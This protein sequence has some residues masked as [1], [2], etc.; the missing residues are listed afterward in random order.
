[1]KTRTA[2]SAVA[3]FCDAE[4]RIS[5]PGLTSSRSQTEIAAHISTSLKALLASQGEY[6]GQSG[7]VAHAK[8]LQK[9]LCLRILSL[10]ELLD[11]S[12]AHDVTRKHPVVHRVPPS[13]TG[14]FYSARKCDP[15]GSMRSG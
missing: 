12:I 4:L 8:D 11:L 7:D 15:G 2:R 3:G 5:V 14:T 6:V 10:A 9:C 13:S 1:V